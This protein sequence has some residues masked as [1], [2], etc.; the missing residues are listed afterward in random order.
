MPTLLDLLEIPRPLDL[1][2]RSAAEHLRNGEELE[3]RDIFSEARGQSLIPVTRGESSWISPSFGVTRG[4]L[5]LIQQ[6]TPS[7]L[8]YELYDLSQDPAEQNNVY[9]QRADEVVRLRRLLERY[10]AD[11]GRRR[12]ELRARVRTTARHPAREPRSPSLDEERK[13]KLEALGYLD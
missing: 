5:R 4:H 6:R 11:S 13:K 3:L 2:G 1:T 9:A 12:S 8:R 10:R 7:G